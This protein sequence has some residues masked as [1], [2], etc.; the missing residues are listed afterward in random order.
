MRLRSAVARP[1]AVWKPEPVNND[2]LEGLGMIRRTWVKLVHPEMM[3]R[4]AA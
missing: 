2:P 1:I 3:R 4:K